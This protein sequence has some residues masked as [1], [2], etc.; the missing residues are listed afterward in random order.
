MFHRF[1]FRLNKNKRQLAICF[2]E[3]MIRFIE[4]TLNQE[5]IVE[6]HQAFSLENKLMNEAGHVDK[7][8]WKRF[9]KE[10]VKPYKIKAK[11]VH[12]VIPTSNVIVRQHVMPNLPEKELKQMIHYEIGNTIHL[13]FE[14]PV[15]DIV[16]IKTE[17]AIYK[18]DGEEGSQVVLVAAPG[19]MIYPIVE[20]L[21]DVGLEVK[22]V[23]IPAT[24][25]Y[26]LFKTNYP[27]RKEEPMIIAEIMNHGVDLHIFDR[28]ILWF[29]R[30]IQMD[31]TEEPS[32]IEGTINVKALLERI[33]SQE[34]YQSFVLDLANEM[35]RAMNF[36]QYTLNNRDQA[37]NSCWIVSKHK[38]NEN[39]YLYLQNRLEIEVNPLI[40]QPKSTKVM[41]VDLSGYDKG[42]GTLCREVTNRGN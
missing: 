10:T 16:K 12:V 6:I 26:R 15:V 40:Y 11:Q 21:L 1:K 42:I 36:F 41:S 2:E 19:Q 27:E 25:L 34:Y 5:R 8:S 13:P 4:V 23:D 22:S 29:T 39:F 14:L 7:E 33:Q 31:F 18:D 37:I 17:G 3:K 9:L 28:G 24:S 38:L 35:E 20:G 32:L 30:H